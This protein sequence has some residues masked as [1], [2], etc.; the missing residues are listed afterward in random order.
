LSD[1][2]DPNTPVDWKSLVTELH[3]LALAS[4]GRR[5]KPAINVLHLADYSEAGIE[6][7]INQIESMRLLFVDPIRLGDLAYEMRMRLAGRVGKSLAPRQSS[8][9]SGTLS[10]FSSDPGVTSAF[11]AGCQGTVLFGLSFVLAAILL[12]ESVLA[13]VGQVARH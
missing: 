4:L 9:V 5:S 10:G 1:D 8:R 11:V 6:A 13:D 2:F 12:A 3:D 7:A